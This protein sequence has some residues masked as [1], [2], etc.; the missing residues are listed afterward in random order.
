VTFELLKRTNVC[1][2]A[3]RPQPSVGG[4]M[5]SNRKEIYALVKGSKRG[6]GLDINFIVI[7]VMN[8]FA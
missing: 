7:L 2:G 3:R 1:L 4:W 8:R 5:D 6:K